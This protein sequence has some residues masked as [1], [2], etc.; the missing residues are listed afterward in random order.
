MLLN[1][2]ELLICLSKNEYGLISLEYTTIC[3]KYNFKDTVKWLYKSDSIYKIEVHSELYQTS[4]MELVYENVY[5]G[6]WICFVIG[7]C[8]VSDYARDT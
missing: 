3:L 6:V 8:Q 5:L 4:K 1:V 2:L 7:I